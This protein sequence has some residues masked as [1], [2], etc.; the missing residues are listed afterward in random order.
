[1]CIFMLGNQSQAN[2]PE[3]LVFIDCDVIPYQIPSYLIPYAH[4]QGNLST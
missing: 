4:Y 2:H 1:M 3:Y